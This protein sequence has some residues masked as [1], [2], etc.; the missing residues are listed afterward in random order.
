MLQSML[1]L[2]LSNGLAHFQTTL[3]GFAALPRWN[4]RG[5]ADYIYGQKLYR[6]SSKLYSSPSLEHEG[7]IGMDVWTISPRGGFQMVKV[8]GFG[9][10]HNF[11]K[12]YLYYQVGTFQRLLPKG[13]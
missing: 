11:G 8:A 7:E 1:E 12:A 5:G 9:L 4:T 10:P 3:V 13:T 6:E 2:A